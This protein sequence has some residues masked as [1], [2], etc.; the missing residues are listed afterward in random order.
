MKKCCFIIPYFGRFNNY[1]QLFLNSCRENPTFNWLIFTDD[2]SNYDYPENVRVVYTSFD[3]I[4]EQFQSKFDFKIALD[5]PYKLCDFKPTYGYVFEDYL[6][7]YKFWGEC[8]ID[9][10][11]GDL[12]K[13]LSDD[14]LDRFDKILCLGHLTIYRNTYEN[15]RVFMQPYREELM[16]KQVFS[17]P[18][19]FGFDEEGTYGNIN[20]IFKES[21]KKVF[22]EDLSLNFEVRRT[23]FV[24]TVHITGSDIIGLDSFKNEKY[25]NA[26]Y[27][28]NKGKVERYY[29]KHH[30]LVREEF[31]Y[32]HLQKRKMTLDKSILSSNIYKIVPNAFLPLEVSEVTISNFSKIKK[33]IFCT[34]AFDVRWPIYKKRMQD[35]FNS[36]KRKR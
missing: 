7:E 20:R 28:W 8:D 14:F 18:N 10:L 30:K 22:E 12:G 36:F 6:K 29:I 27:I 9:T 21:G 1:F 4:V 13:F 11:M 31:P 2:K 16:Y 23:H 33:H 25:I 15:N 3:K 24:R 35:M 32:M 17:S 5:R 19:S 26:L 34:H